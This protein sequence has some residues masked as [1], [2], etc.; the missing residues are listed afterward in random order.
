MFIPRVITLDFGLMYHRRRQPQWRPYV[1]PGLGALFLLVLF[2]NRDFFRHVPPPEAGSTVG[3]VEIVPQPK[4]VPNVISQIDSVACR[5]AQTANPL[6]SFETITKTPT[7]E[8]PNKESLVYRL[9]NLRVLA[10]TAAMQEALLIMVVTKDKTSWGKGRTAQDFIALVQTFDYPAH[11]ISIGI[12][13][14]SMEEYVQLKRLFQRT[15]LT[16]FAQVTI[17][18]R[19]D[20]NVRIARERRHDDDVQK[21]RRR[22]IARY[23][24]VALSQCL[25]PWHSHVVWIDSD[26]I[27]IPTYLVSKMVAAKLDILEPL[28]NLKH[29]HVDYDLNAWEGPRLTPTPEEL[30]ALHDGDT[31]AFVG[32]SGR[33]T[34]HI[35]DMRWHEYHPLDSVGGTMLYVK[36]DIH[37]QGVLFTTHYIIG[38][39]WK[40]EGYDGIETEG[41]CYVAGMLGYKC[42]AMPQD[43]IIH[44]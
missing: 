30:K 40:H 44:I 29:G 17:I 43:I 39:E 4:G 28:C 2:I 36:A 27:S 15:L 19:D 34:R 25:E 20:L 1:M 13:T 5:A 32:G 21:I 6:E 16:H 7:A 37:R 38:N 35:K 11:K 14:S 18:F 41:L 22:T 12:L 23:R 9:K 24:N 10:T 42:Y 33:G 3:S 8:H 31:T 26:I